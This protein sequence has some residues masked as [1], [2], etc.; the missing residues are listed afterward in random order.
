ME[1]KYENVDGEIIKVT[2]QRETVSEEAM[3]AQINDIDRQIASNNEVIERS[4][5]YIDTALASNSEL[6]K[7]RA[8]IV[9]LLNDVVVPARL[10]REALE[11]PIEEVIEE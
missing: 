4:Q 11:A 1:Q 8:E 7:Q 5:W 10:E 3:N 6:E 9:G 2:T